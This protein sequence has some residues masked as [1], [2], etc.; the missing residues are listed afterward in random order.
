MS[1]IGASWTRRLP[2]G[3]SHLLLFC[4]SWFLIEFA[5]QLAFQPI[6]QHPFEHLSLDASSK[7]QLSQ[8]KDRLDQQDQGGLFALHPYAGYAGRPGGQPWQE[9]EHIFSS[10]GFLG[11]EDRYRDLQGSP[12]LSESQLSIAI[13]GGSV[14]ERFAL[15]ED[16]A[17][18]LLSELDADFVDDRELRII[19]LAMSAYK[20]P[21][22]LFMLQYALLQGV[23]I[24]LVLNL[25]G[26][27]ELALAIENTEKD[28]P[29]IYPSV[30]NMGLLLQ[31]GTGRLDEAGLDYLQNRRSSLEREA[32]WWRRSRA[33]IVRQSR[34]INLIAN[35]R[36]QAERTTRQ[37]RDIAE[38]DRLAQ[39]LETEAAGPAITSSE[40]PAEA[41]SQ[42]WARSSELLDAVCK[43][44]KIPYVHVLQPSQ[45]HAQSKA[46]TEE[47]L[48]TA[49]DPDHPWAISAR[50]HYPRLIE[51]GQGLR[52]AGLDFHD[53]SHVF[54]AYP[55][56]S[57]YVD[58][59]CH[60]TDS[61]NSILADAIVPLIVE[62]FEQSGQEQ[63]EP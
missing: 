14:A 34:L 49:Y 33:P 8:I 19:P 17:Q 62:A 32:R 59:C 2:K 9:E 56:T 50:E 60:L 27:N 37:S 35:L 13:L 28:Y 45:Y 51:E 16:L 54:E 4:A 24:D 10:F 38:Q 22:Q 7:T 1:K 29:S 18:R 30:R 36:I 39:W 58:T 43:R 21:Q 57:A 48:R 23:D 20:Q 15:S 47:E 53:L 3:L 11:L 44:Q 52:E 61:G 25:D 46:L 5:A 63:S 12:A 6:T 41:A 42:V 40:P 26:F 55:Q 31:E